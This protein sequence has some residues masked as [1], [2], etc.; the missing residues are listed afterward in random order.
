MLLLLWGCLLKL[1]G[2]TYWNRSPYQ[3]NERR[4]PGP[5][6]PCGPWT[7]STDQVH[8]LHGPGPWIGSIDCMDQVHGPPIFLT[9]KSKLYIVPVMDCR[10]QVVS[11]GVVVSGIDRCKTL[12]YQ[13]CVYQFN[14]KDF[15]KG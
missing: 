3:K 13:R 15:K 10:A 8:Q 1:E 4:K 9:P 2:G 6:V 11:G 7:G 12:P 14:Q 5:L